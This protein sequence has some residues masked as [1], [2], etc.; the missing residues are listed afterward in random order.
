M[1]YPRAPPALLENQ[2]MPKGEV[3]GYVKTF[4]IFDMLESYKMLNQFKHISHVT[5]IDIVLL[6]RIME[7]LV[8]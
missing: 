7:N 4:Y 3:R 1:R 5:I 8:I 6:I 2:T